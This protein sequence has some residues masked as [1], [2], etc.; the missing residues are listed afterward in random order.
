MSNDIKL[1][2][3]MLAADGSNWIT[4]RDRISWLM[5]MRG[6]GDHLMSTTVTK[7]YKD[8]GDV[9]GLKPEQR[10]TADENAA[11]QLIGATI[12]DSVFHKIKMANFVKDVWDR[13]KGLFEGKSRTL[14]IDLGRKLQNMRCGDSEDVRAHL[15]KLADLR[16]RLSALGRTVNDDEYVSVLI[17]SLPTSYDTTIN[18][19]T[20]SCDVTNT[21]ITPTSI[22]RIATNEYEK[23][24]L[25]K[26]KG[27]VQDEAF[28]AEEQCK[29]KRRNIECFNCHRKGHYKSEC[30]AKGGGKEGEG[31]KKST[32]CE[33]SEDKAKDKHTRDS[34]NAATEESS[35]DESWAAIIDVDDEGEGETCNMLSAL[36]DSAALTTD[37][38]P[39]VELYDSGASRHMSPSCHRFT[40]LRSIPPRP[41]TAANGKPFYAIGVGDLKIAVP[42]GA[43]TT[44][45]TLKD[46]LYAPDMGLMVISISRI[47]GAGYS[48]RFEGN[49]CKIQNKKSAIMGSIAA[50]PNGLYKVKHPLM[51]VAAVEQINILML[52]RRLGHIAADTIRSLVRTNAVTRLH[53]IDPSSHSQITCDSC[54][55]AKA[56]RKTICKESTL[57]LA[58]AFGDEV[59]S[60]VWGPSPVSSLGGRKYYITF[61]DD[62]TCFTRLDLLHTKDEALNAYKAF[63]AWVH[64]QHG[65]H[66]KQLHSDCG[67]EYTSHE[68]TSF[69]QLQGTERH[70]TTHDMP[71]HN[72]VAESLNRRLLEWVHAILHHSQ[73]PKFLWG[74][75][76]H[77]IVW[78]KNHTT[79]R[80]LGKITPFE[81]L[82]GSKPDLGGVPEWGQRV[83]V[84]RAPGSKLDGR[85]AEARWVGFDTNST[86]AHRVYWQGKNSVSVERNIKFS[87]ATVTI[88]SLPPNTPNYTPP[89][90]MAEE[91]QGP[92]IPITLQ[93]AAA[94]LPTPPISIATN[95][96]ISAPP[97]TLMPVHLPQPPPATNSG[98]EELPDEDDRPQTPQ[99]QGYV[100]PPC[101]PR[102][103]LVPALTHKSARLA[104]KQAQHLSTP[105]GNAPD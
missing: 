104:T 8:A 23:C 34:A 35:K 9:A 60:D 40:N 75:A 61:T 98:E 88:P 14:L 17:G 15:E 19:L 62:H 93:Q 65:V 18:T 50:S 7:S 11:S 51:A 28:T 45:I 64:T 42:N 91:G 100:Y 21:D 27:K 52:H 78:L 12:P 85:A 84:H 68:F 58:E 76:T 32:K 10:W 90:G 87:P 53:L 43:S 80:A 13:L 77:F 24:L 25:R 48:V 33:D 38:K 41:I 26:G 79:T 47:A 92:A 89:A 105:D 86:H 97:S 46:A 30:W 66:I 36:T 67:S 74:E 55:Y 29:N 3:P 81:Q 31:L 63:A 83:W 22:I 72:G 82:Y 73:L 6:L 102:K 71:Q 101:A 95:M 44:S 57:P 16:E 56:T 2:L 20:T 59:H 37:S 94:L 70:L 39:N 4:Y 49:R 54:D 69:L 99:H 96:P 5:K 1:C 103:A